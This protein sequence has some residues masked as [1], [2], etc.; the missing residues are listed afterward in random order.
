MTHR[1]LQQRP[2]KR[3][4]LSI[5][6][7]SS[8]QQL[9][10]TALELEGYDVLKA[11]GGAAGLALARAVLPQLILLDVMLL[12]GDEGLDLCRAIV[13]DLRL[14]HIP[15]VMISPVDDVAAIE[16]GLAA[17]AKGYLVKPFYPREL[18]ALANRLVSHRNTEA[19]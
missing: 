16:A 12:P 11:Q 18:V 3:T 10:R 17:G 4:I 14:G 13:Q 2:L 6:D 19:P 8:F 9:V 5:E 7:V 15:V 1:P